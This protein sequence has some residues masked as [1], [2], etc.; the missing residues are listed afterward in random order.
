MAGEFSF[1]GVDYTSGSAVDILKAILKPYGLDG[2]AGRMYDVGKNSEHDPNV[3]YLWLRDQ[4]EYKAAFPGMTLREKNKLAP[5]T[6]QQYIDWKSQAISTMRNNGIPSN[7]Y[8]S[9]DDFS[10][11][12]G[13]GVSP[14]EF[15]QRVVNGVV[16]VQQAPKE[17]RDALFNYYGVD[18]GHLAAYWLDPNNKGKD[19]LFQKAASFIGGQAAQTD[20]GSISR[21]EAERLASAGV[22][23]EQAQ[24]R[25]GELGGAQELLSNMAGEDQKDQFTREEQIGYAANDPDAQR[26]LA[27]RAQ[28]RKAA[29]SGGGSYAEGAAGVSGL[30]KAE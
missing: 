6:E 13:N 26:E 4:P 24:A 3:A 16:A 17:V 15:E 28:R 1:Q 5:L 23:P 21:Q 8:D 10:N 9:E 22:A 27:R 14:Q 29:F 19:L 30:G 2:L 7:F 20:F 12:I 18:D 11:F 25:F